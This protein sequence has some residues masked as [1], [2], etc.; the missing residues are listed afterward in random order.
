M[1][2][3]CNECHVAMEHSFIVVKTPEAPSFPD[4]DFTTKS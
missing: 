2:A 3:A 4:Q 1:T